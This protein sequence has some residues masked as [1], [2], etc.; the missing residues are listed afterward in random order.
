[1]RTLSSY[2]IDGVTLVAYD[3]AD[4]LAAQ[5]VTWELQRDDY[6][7]QDLRL[8]YGDIVIDIGAHV[9]LFSMY[10]AKRWP[11]QR[12]WPSNPSP[13]TIATGQTTFE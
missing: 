1:M 12:F 3:Q 5:W 7:I 13:Q 10:I 6:R 2:T 11:T 9:G 4:S 8:D